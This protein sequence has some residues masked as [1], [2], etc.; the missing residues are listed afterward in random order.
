MFE[1]NRK[2]TDQ[3]RRRSQS[4]QS[5]EEDNCRKKRRRTREIEHSKMAR[6]WQD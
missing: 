5:S 4:W 1:G 3:L 2:D 6:E